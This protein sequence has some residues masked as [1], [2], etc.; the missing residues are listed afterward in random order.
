MEK[1]WLPKRLTSTSCAYWEY[2]KLSND[3]WPRF[4]ES[5]LAFHLPIV[6][7]VFD[8]QKSVSANK[9]PQIENSLQ[10]KTIHFS[11]NKNFENW[12]V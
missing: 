10:R 8:L 12:D 7:P 4:G 3:A 11:Q 1:Q 6:K 9:I 2:T 5:N